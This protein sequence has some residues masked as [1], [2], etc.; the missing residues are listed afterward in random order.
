[1]AA[2]HSSNA[3]TGGSP[4]AT[5]GFGSLKGGVAALSFDLRPLEG[6]YFSQ[7]FPVRG[8]KL[9][10]RGGAL[11]IGRPDWANYALTLEL[12]GKLPPPTVRLNVNER[13]N[14][15]LEIAWDTKGCMVF[16]TQKGLTTTSKRIP[17]PIALRELGLRSL[18]RELTI[19]IDGREIGRVSLP[20]YSPV[21]GS[22]QILAAR[23]LRRVEVKGLRQ[24]YDGF[25]GC[26]GNNSGLVDPS[27]RSM[28]SHS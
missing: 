11:N 9:T 21:R 27:R 18:D 6:I 3:P 1:M 24:F 8:L 15:W 5:C 13:E 19:L 26:D 2:E 22:V 16:S 25:G 12:D 20:E 7:E 28:E 17:W 23:G 4:G 10:D 14:S